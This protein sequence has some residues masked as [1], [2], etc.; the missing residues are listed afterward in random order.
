MIGDKRGGAVTR[1]IADHPDF[2]DRTRALV[3]V[4]LRL[5]HVVRNPFDNIATI[6]KRHRMNLEDAAD[7]YFRHVETNARLLQTLSCDELMTIRHE[8]LSPLR[9]KA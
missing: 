9:H 5:I 6:S 1:A 2:L 7:Y 4:P 3:D 8:D